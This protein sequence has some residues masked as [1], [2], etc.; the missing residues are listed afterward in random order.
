MCVE[1]VKAVD[2]SDPIPPIQKPSGYGGVGI[3]WR[4]SL[5]PPVTVLEDG[6][7]SIQ[8]VRVKTAG[9]HILIISVCMHSKGK[10]TYSYI[11]MRGILCQTSRNPNG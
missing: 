1:Q 3:L 2:D 8:C 5:D 6:S 10:L 11:V 4:K 7:E 9:G